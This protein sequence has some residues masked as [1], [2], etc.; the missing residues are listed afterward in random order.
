MRAVSVVTYQPTWT[1][2]SAFE[3]TFR[4]GQRKRKLDVAD[5]M[6]I[7]AI[8]GEGAAALRASILELLALL[9]YALN[10]NPET[11]PA[12]NPHGLAAQLRDK[13]IAVVATDLT[14]HRRTGCGTRGDDNDDDGD[15]NC[16]DDAEVLFEPSLRLWHSLVS[17]K[18]ATWSPGLEQLMPVLTGGGYN[19]TDGEFERHSWSFDRTLYARLESSEH[20]QVC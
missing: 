1:H 18:G 19:T 12:Q 5:W 20:A 17:G 8:S 4:C 9:L 7:V 15:D 2:V 10:A 16:N 13:V 6:V 11:G 3:S 14:A